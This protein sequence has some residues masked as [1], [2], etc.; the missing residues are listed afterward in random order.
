[1]RYIEL[2]PRLVFFTLLFLI[3]GSYSL[4]EARFLILGPHITI[5]EPQDGA[6]VSQSV[7][8]TKGVAHNIAYISLNDRPIFVDQQGNFEEKVIMFPGLNTMTMRAKDRFGRETD[9]TIRIVYNK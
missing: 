9:K 8:L 5:T 7:I 3:V 6:R 4:F 2:T 1:M